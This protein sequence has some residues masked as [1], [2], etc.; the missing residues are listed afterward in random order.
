VVTECFTSSHFKGFGSTLMRTRQRFINQLLT[1]GNFY[2]PRTSDGTVRRS[3]NTSSMSCRCQ[4]GL[5]V[6]LTTA[7]IFSRTS[8]LRG[9]PRHSLRLDPASTTIDLFLY[10][11]Y[12]WLARRIVIIA[13]PSGVFRRGALCEPPPPGRTTV[14]FLKT[15]FHA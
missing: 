1:D 8:T 11:P 7:S 14:I 15:N 12:H 4:S 2:N 6:M 10:R 5:A 9:V 13:P 3:P